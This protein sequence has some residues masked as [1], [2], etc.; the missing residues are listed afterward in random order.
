M[1]SKTRRE[2]DVPEA[3]NMGVKSA[4][5]PDLKRWRSARGRTAADER[6]KLSDRG[7][8]IPRWFHSDVR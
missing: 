4:V 1:L 7:M 2:L 8:P 3:G 6:T 5:E